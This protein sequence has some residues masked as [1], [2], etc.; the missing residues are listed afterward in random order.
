MSLKRE[1]ISRYPY[2]VDKYGINF[3]R[4]DETD[5]YA[6]LVGTAGSGRKFSYR[7]N[8][9]GVSV[10][11]PT[12]FPLNLRGYEIAAQMMN[13]ETVNFSLFTMWCGIWHHPDMYAGIFVGLAVSHFE[14]NGYDVKSWVDEWYPYSVNY[15]RYMKGLKMGLSS[16]EA[17]SLTWSGIQAKKLGFKPQS[18]IPGS[19][20]DEGATVFKF[21]RK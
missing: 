15:K 6:G 11:D 1:S 3:S 18:E 20:R 17:A 19:Y 8:Q 21:V 4:F 10:Y 14:E 9:R 7:F 13:D 2:V 16:S 5:H 12:I